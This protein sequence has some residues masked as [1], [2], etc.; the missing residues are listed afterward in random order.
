MFILII[1]LAPT[2]FFGCFENG[3]KTELSV[4]HVQG[5]KDVCEESSSFSATNYE[6]RNEIRRKF[7]CDDDSANK[8]RSQRGMKSCNHN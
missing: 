5:I 7:N 2:F 6:R 4:R 3:W 1:I 8:A